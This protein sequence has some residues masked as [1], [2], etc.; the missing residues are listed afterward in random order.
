MWSRRSD[1]ETAAVEH[2]ERRQ[3]TR[4]TPACRSKI[5]AAILV[6]LIIQLTV[7]V[8]CSGSS[9]KG[10]QAEW[11]RGGTATI[12]GVRGTI[13][14]VLSHGGTGE[15]LFLARGRA[16]GDG[17]IENTLYSMWVAD[18]EGE[19]LLLDFGRAREECEVDPD[20]GK[21]DDCEVEV[22]LR[23]RRLDE[24]PFNVTSLL[25]LTATISQLPGEVPINLSELE[26][27]V[28]LEFTV[29]DA[30]L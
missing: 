12:P 28:V 9:S 8:A 13:E 17:L 6:L 21:K 29:A 25:G 16:E 10:G 22:M 26:G 19:L 3:T 7:V 1:E 30:D 24:V 2:S 27:Q 11:P 15:G 4:R 20:T 14:L 5:V 23:S 18:P